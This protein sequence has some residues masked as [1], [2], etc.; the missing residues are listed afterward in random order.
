M[1][2]NTLYCKHRCKKKGTQEIHEL[3]QREKEVKIFDEAFHI[4]KSKEETKTAEPLGQLTSWWESFI[5]LAELWC[6]DIRIF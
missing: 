2:F 5:F 3:L 1:Y 6:L 4:N